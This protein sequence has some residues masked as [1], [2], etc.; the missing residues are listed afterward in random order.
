MELLAKN[1]REKLH[2][3]VAL[4]LP[5]LGTQLATMGMGFFDA[6]MSG[7]AGN[8]DLAGTAIGSNAWAPIHTGFS[9]V[10]LAAM[11]LIANTIGAGEREK[12]PNILCQGMLLA[13]A[14]GLI[15][16]LG[17]IF[18]LPFF[19]GN[20]GLATEVYNIALWYCAGVGIGVIP[21]LL[22]VPL[23]SLIDSLGH[24]DLTMK[25]YLIGLP[26]NALLNYVLIF[27][28]L[29]LPRLGGIGAGLA[30]GI[31]YWLMFGLFVISIRFVQEFRQYNPFSALIV[32]V[33]QIKE[34]LRIGIPLGFSIFLEVGVFCIVA[35]FMAKFGTDTIAAFQAAMNMAA[36]VYM[37]PLS[38]SMALTIVVGIS[39]GAKR[40]TEAKLYGRLGIELSIALAFFYLMAEFFGREAIAQIYSKD[41]E[42]QKLMQQFIVF[43]IVWQCGDTIAAPIQGMLRGFKDVDAVFWSSV[44]AYWIICLP[45]GVLLDYKFNCGAFAYWESLALGVICSAI[46]MLARLKWF[47]KRLD[48]KP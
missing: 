19:F 26:I 43:A 46:C 32:D 9:G 7:Q 5:I 8:I 45:V 24:T 27:G 23:R 18:L 2:K 21:M 30:T 31:T 47:Y 20:M 1:N 13:I 36:L 33:K 35:F 14:F 25:L 29:G 40:Y 10:L 48:N 22:T 41:I 3:L 38:F 15:I 42:V 11:P 16:I 37:I 34:Y 17:G 12:I 44:L 4:M 39:Y 28:K 6:S